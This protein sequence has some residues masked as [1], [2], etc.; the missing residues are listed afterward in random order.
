MATTLKKFPAPVTLSA[1]SE[2]FET[3]VSNLY[4]EINLEESGL[5][6]K[7][8]RMLIRISETAR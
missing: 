7:Y 3:E 5:A 1:S 8:L 2:K 4:C 6:V